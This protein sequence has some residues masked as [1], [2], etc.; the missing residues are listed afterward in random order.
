M[1]TLSQGCI[2]DG[3]PGLKRFHCVLLSSL[4]TRDSTHDCRERRGDRPG[5]DSTP[6]R[7]Y[8][9]VR[10]AFHISLDSYQAESEGRRDRLSCFSSLPSLCFQISRR[11]VDHQSLLPSPSL[12]RLPFMQQRERCGRDLSR[13]RCLQPDHLSKELFFWT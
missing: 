7:S 12:P 3:R 13:M 2:E 1:N 10:L 8:R 11:S 5:R 9:L 6:L 4:H